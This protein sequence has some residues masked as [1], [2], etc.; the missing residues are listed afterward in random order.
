MHINMTDKNNNLCTSM[1]VVVLSV[2]TTKDGQM[3]RGNMKIHF[4]RER[5]KGKKILIF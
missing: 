1:V 4:I 3:G 5:E 2:P